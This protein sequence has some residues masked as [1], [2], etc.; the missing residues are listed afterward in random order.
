MCKYCIF[1]MDWT[2]RISYVHIGQYYYYYYYYTTTS[3]T[4][5]VRPSTTAILVKLLGL[6][7]L[8]M[9]LPKLHLCI[10]HPGPLRTYI[11]SVCTDTP[12]CSSST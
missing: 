11:S 9:V 4:L 5:L 12:N 6:Q 1:T 10:Y 8:R 7:T 2:S 3:Q